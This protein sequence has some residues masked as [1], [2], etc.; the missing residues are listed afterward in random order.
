VGLLV[1][2]PDGAVAPGLYAAGEVV[3]D[4]SRTWLQ[5]LES[6]ALAGLAASRGA[7]AATAPRPAE[8][9]SSSARPP[10]RP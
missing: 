10:T 1:G 4:T 9:T 5:A 7:V 2:A 8:P 6:G 3:A